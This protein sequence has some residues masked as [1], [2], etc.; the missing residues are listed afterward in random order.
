MRDGSLT[1]A[2]YQNAFARFLKKTAVG[3]K[4]LRHM[5]VH[6]ALTA[7]F[8]AQPFGVVLYT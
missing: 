7:Q 3:S 1:K 8:F 4:K 6:L 5:G 2:I